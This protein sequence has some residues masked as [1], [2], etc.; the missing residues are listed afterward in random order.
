MALKVKKFFRN[1][2]VLVTLSGAYFITAI[3]LILSGLACFY[4]TTPLMFILIVL[5]I[6]SGSYLGPLWF[7][8]FLKAKSYQGEYRNNQLILA[9]ELHCDLK[10][11]YIVKSDSLNACAL[12][13]GKNKT[14]CFNSIVF[15][16]CSWNEIKAVTAHEIGHHLNG[17]IYLYTSIVAVILIVFS[18]L[19]VIFT[20][21][22][23]SLIKLIEFLLL[24]SLVLVPI[25][26]AI[27]RWRE[28]LEDDFAKEKLGNANGLGEFLKKVVQDAV[29][30]G[31]NIPVTPSLLRRFTGT[32]PWI[33][34]RIR[35]LEI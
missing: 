32:H 35:N 3:L 12:S 27:S 26:L 19:G 16:R 8:L 21:S 22:S 11:I 1:H 17:D 10:D 2:P 30:D 24:I 9:K 5:I 14:L 28:G 23:H 33:Y 18:W 25:E 34:E 6:F 13:F 4:F 15:N 31:I 20:G 7:R 29:R